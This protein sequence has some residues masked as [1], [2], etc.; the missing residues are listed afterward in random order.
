L[1]LRLSPD[2]TIAMGMMVMTPG[3]AL[4]AENVEMVA[5]RLPRRGGIDAYERLLIASMEGDADDV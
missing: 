5:S 3:E 4:S 2:V 1:R